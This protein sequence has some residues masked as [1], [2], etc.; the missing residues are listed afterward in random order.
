MLVSLFDLKVWS[1]VDQAYVC[2]VNFVKLFDLPCLFCGASSGSGMNAF[3]FS[4]HNVNSPK[5]SPFNLFSNI[6]LSLDLTLFGRDKALDL[7]GCLLES[8]MEATGME[9]CVLGFGLGGGLSVSRRVNAFCF[10]SGLMSVI[11][12]S[13]DEERRALILLDVAVPRWDCHL[14]AVLHLF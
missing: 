3:I 13:A 8:G 6:P 14:D 2:L 7:W 1:A 5:S 11:G 12:S 9:E 4:L 10:F